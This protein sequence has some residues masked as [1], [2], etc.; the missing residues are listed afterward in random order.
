[1]ADQE[2]VAGVEIEK[3][4]QLEEKIKIVIR[5]RNEFKSEIERLRQQTK[6]LESEFEKKNEGILQ[7]QNIKRSSSV[8]QKEYDQLLAERNTIRDKVEDLLSKIDS[9]GLEL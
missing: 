3:L 7:P 5:Q 9:L 1:L 2:A 8:D 6:D 4:T